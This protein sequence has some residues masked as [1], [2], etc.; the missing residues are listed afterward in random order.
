MNI[1][2][3]QDRLTPG[4]TVSGS[5]HLVDA[6]EGQETF[7]GELHDVH[8]DFA[9]HLVMSVNALTALKKV[10]AAQG[11]RGQLATALRSVL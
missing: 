11:T 5:L 10:I 4:G 8:P 1:K 7:L 2:F 3:V 9:K 6:E